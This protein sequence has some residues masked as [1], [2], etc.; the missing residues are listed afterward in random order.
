MTQITWPKIYFG[1]INLWN[2]PK[3]D[4]NIH[5]NKLIDENMEKGFQIR[6]VVNEFRDVEYIQL[7][8]YFLSY[9][10]EFIPSKEGV[11]VPATIENIYSLLDGLLEI[12]AE[13]EGEDIIQRYAEKV[14]GWTGK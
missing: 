10:G 1:P 14:L 4:D 3:M 8:K 7:R 9:E 13:A 6:L 12:C 5:Y 11:S 2:L